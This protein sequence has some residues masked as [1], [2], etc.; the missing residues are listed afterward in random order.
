MNYLNLINK[1]EKII[2]ENYNNSNI[3]KIYVE[4]P[5]Y[6][7]LESSN[8]K[9][10]YI[11]GRFKAIF[12]ILNQKTQNG[13]L[14][15]DEWANKTIFKNE[16]F[17][18]K[19]KKKLILGRLD[20]PENVN[21]SVETASHCLI[22]VKKVGNELWGTFEVFATKPYG[23]NLWALLNAGVILGLSIRGVGDEIYDNGVKKVSEDDFELI[24][25]D[26]VVDASSMGSE[27]KEFTESKRREILSK[28]VNMKN[29]YGKNYTRYFF[30]SL[31]KEEKIKK[32]IKMKEKE[33]EE[34][35]NEVN[36]LKKKINNYNKIKEDKNEIEDKYIREIKKYQNNESSLKIMLES[37][38][39]IIFNLKKVIGEKDEEIKA[40]KSE[41]ESLKK[42]NERLKVMES[43]NSDNKIEV[44][45]N[46]K[47]ND[48]NDNG[49]VK[50]MILNSSMKLRK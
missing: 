37:K 47:N 31:I 33:I 32:E 16:A 48:I 15:T 8:I 41:I 42:I 24:G 6:E 28:V 12:L 45:I 7:I 1:S 36:R 17:K 20:H 34:L 23:E 21:G 25:I 46:N 26:V 18:N 22:D 29:E 14:Y 3:K 2:N 5:K 40:Y 11:L 50:K 13:T 35:N 39:K 43:K 4:C 19:L 10:K 30:E 9:N 27:F 44:V 49:F 38:D